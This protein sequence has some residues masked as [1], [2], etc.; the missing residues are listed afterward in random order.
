[1]RN[2]WEFVN[3]R[4]ERQESGKLRTERCLLNR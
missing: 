1:L 3:D 4:V 2:G